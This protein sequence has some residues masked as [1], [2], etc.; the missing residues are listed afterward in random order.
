MNSEEV[1]LEAELRCITKPD[2]SARFS[3][4]KFIIFK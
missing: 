3:I 4:S 2:G 1:K